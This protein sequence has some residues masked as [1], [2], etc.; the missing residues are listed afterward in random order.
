MEKKLKKKVVQEDKD[1]TSF[2]EIDEHQLDKEWVSQPR[3]MLIY[4][5]KLADAK[6][7]LDQAEAELEVVDAEL[8]R[9]IRESPETFDCPKTTDKAIEQ[10]VQLQ[11]PY[12]RAVRAVNLAKH[13]VAIYQ[14][15]VNALNHRKS[16]LEGLVTLWSQSYFSS[17][18]APESAKEEMDM[19]ERRAARKKIKPMKRREE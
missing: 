11:K 1:D 3:R 18:K 9:D 14:A 6:L 16:A 12:L 4:S 2:I 17:P 15:A 19:V 7:A 13:E 8:A 10:T 5:R